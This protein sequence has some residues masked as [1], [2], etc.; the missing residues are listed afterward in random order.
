MVNELIDN[1]RETPGALQCDENFNSSLQMSEI[2]CK[3]AG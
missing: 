1:T 2:K 3:A